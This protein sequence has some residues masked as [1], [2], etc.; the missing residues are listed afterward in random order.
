MRTCCLLLFIALFAGCKPGRKVNTS[1]YYWKTVYKQNALENAYLKKTN[2]HK[3]YV[4]I[5]DVDLSMD[6]INPVPVSPIIFRDKMADSLQIVPV[7]FIVND[8]LRNLSKQKIDDLADKLLHF[9]YAK[10]HQAGK[11]NYGELQIDCDWTT[12][13]RE[14]Y[15]YLLLQLKQRLYHKTISATLRLHQ[16]KNQ[17]GSGI[18]P[19]NKVLLMCYNM[20]NLRKYGI[21]NSIID[22]SELKKYLGD[23]LTNYPI[24]ID[25]G[26]PLFSWAVTF[27]NKKYIG[28]DKRINFDIL[29]TRNQFEYKGDGLYSAK[30]DLPTYGLK[31]ADIVR[32]ENAPLIDIQTINKYIARYLKADSVNVVYFNLDEAV[33]KKYTYD[34]LQNT[35]N[36]LR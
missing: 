5:T 19:V 15:F 3:I 31:K 36:L 22:V 4:R 23:N 21:Q 24:P 14:N 25:I 27:K 29:N 34:E 18:P 13:T 32:W 2:V 11:A 9:V 20:G 17:R 8:V 26:L 7:V 12:Q 10:I 16:L 35:S 1:F 33:I 30:T 28:I 6:G